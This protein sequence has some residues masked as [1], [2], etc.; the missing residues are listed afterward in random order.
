MPIQ[1][2]L[3]D[4]AGIGPGATVMPFA[5]GASDDPSGPAGSAANRQRSQSPPGDVGSND[6]EAHAESPAKRQ[7][8]Q[9]PPGDVGRTIS[10]RGLVLS[11]VTATLSASLLVA[12]AGSTQSTTC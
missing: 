7:R 10:R 2:P 5:C 9:S 11:G 3:G 6:L 8:S 12:I 4:F 1:L